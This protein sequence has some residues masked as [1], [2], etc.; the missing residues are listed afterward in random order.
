MRS[1]QN[2]LFLAHALL[3][4]CS[5]CLSVRHLSGPR[6]LTQQRAGQNL[7]EPSHMIAK[8]CLHLLSKASAMCDQSTPVMRDM[9]LSKCWLAALDFVEVRCLN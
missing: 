5:L 7:R 3:L 9:Q 1:I 6:L 4:D 2:S 8:S